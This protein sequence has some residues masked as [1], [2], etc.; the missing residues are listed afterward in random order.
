M[1]NIPFTEIYEFC[2]N[3]TKLVKIPQCL[4]TVRKESILLVEQNRL[5]SQVYYYSC[6]QLINLIF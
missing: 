5:P 4:L 3:D 6:R 2:T 1:S